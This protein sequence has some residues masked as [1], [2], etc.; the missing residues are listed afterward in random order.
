MG[1]DSSSCIFELEI[2][3]LL[4]IKGCDLLY[5]FCVQLWKPWGTFSAQRGGWGRAGKRTPRVC[6][7]CNSFLFC[8]ARLTPR[9]DPHLRMVCVGTTLYST[10]RSLSQ[11]PHTEGGVGK[12]LCIPPLWGVHINQKQNLGADCVPLSHCL[13]PVVRQIQ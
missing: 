6:F 4:E 2:S 9:T 11:D 10:A 8:V 3:K 1:W 13:A 5:V 12:L 7:P